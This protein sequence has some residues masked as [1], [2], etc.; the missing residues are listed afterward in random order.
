MEWRKGPSPE[1]TEAVADQVN[2]PTLREI[3]EWASE[4]GLA[5]ISGIERAELVKR[6]VLVGVAAEVYLTIGIDA[7]VRGPARGLA[8]RLQRGIVALPPIERECCG[9]YV[10]GANRPNRP[11]REGANRLLV[12]PRGNQRASGGQFRHDDRCTVWVQQPCG[13]LLETPSAA[14]RQRLGPVRHD[15][16][17]AVV[18]AVEVQSH[19]ITRLLRIENEPVRGDSNRTRWSLH[20]AKHE[21]SFAFA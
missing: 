4:I 2:Q 7:P 21:G 9:E 20:H 13:G 19:K 14:Q 5:F 17:L 8:S 15:R 3:E 12:V 10:T 1:V 18:E 6:S 16:Q 11:S